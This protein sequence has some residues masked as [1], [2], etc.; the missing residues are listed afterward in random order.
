[1]EE[2]VESMRDAF[3]AR[4][5]QL[6]WMSAETKIAAREKLRTF[7]PKIGYPERWRD[8][9]A[10]DIRAG[11]AFGNLQR[12]IEYEWRRQIDRLDHPVDR[13]EW[14]LAAFTVDAYY[15]PDWNQL[16]F[17]AAILQPPFFDP[18]ADPAV[19]YGG[20]GAVIGHEMGHGLDDQ[21]ARRDARGMLRDWWSEG[22]VQRF[23]A[24]GDR[25]VAQYSSYSPLPGICVNG[26]L[27]L[28]ENIGDLGGLQIAYEAYQRSLSGRPAPVIDGITGD[29]RFFLAFGQIWKRV[30]REQSLRN[31][32]L[33][34]THAPPKYRV[35]G[36]VRNL[37]AWHAAFDV[38]P[39]D[40]LYLAP[41]D[42]ILI[43]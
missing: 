36:V 30:W 40:A 43:W 26:R 8:Y 6:P 42:R 28:G 17:P 15:N 34:D 24:L 27:T 29:Q 20:I 23:N 5:D 33:S 13:S 39:G 11:D 38:Q 3:D 2:V 22:D 19:I 14:F 25:L 10:L 9:S 31:L 21:G 41:S 37:D 7:Q 1:V 18:A 35:N 12:S 4:I 32:V 16:E